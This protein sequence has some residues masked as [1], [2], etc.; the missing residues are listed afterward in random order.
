MKIIKKNE[1]PPEQL[2]NQVDEPGVI[3]PQTK[4]VDIPEQEI[5]SNE[6]EEKD[7]PVLKEKNPQTQ[8]TIPPI[9]ESESE[10]TPNT[11]PKNQTPDVQ[12]F[13]ISESETPPP[14]EKIKNISKII[15]YSSVFI[16]AGLGILLL[17]IYLKNRIDYS[18][19]KSVLEAFINKNIEGKYKDSYELISKESSDKI[20]TG[21]YIKYYKS[22]DSV[23]YAKDSTRKFI[24]SSLD[25]KEVDNLTGN[26]KRFK[27]ESGSIYDK[28]TIK[29]R[30]Y[31]TMFLEDKKW[32]VIWFNSLL[33]SAH[34]E[35]DKS[36]IST[37][38][39]IAKD[40]LIIDPYNGFAYRIICW[41]HFRN[42]NGELSNRINEM[43]NNINQALKLEPDI[44]DNYY[45]LACC[46]VLDNK[47][48]EAIN[49][50]LKGANFNLEKEKKATYYSTL[51]IIYRDI[52][53]DFEN[54]SKYVNIAYNLDSNDTHIVT[55]KGFTFH[56]KEK[57]L[58]ALYYY[59]K[60]LKMKELINTQQASLYYYYSN[61][62]YNIGEYEACKTY[63]KKAYE[64]SPNDPA[65]KGFY[66]LAMK[67]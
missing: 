24:S 49:C 20:T 4:K 35:A 66:Y 42:I 27:T 37:A 7:D 32:K 34:K 2:N 15:L 17:T 59:E 47:I 61:C 43:L 48:D 40:I 60:A 28:D 52:K 3:H 26:Y 38:T 21:E 45:N 56:K 54:Y 62:K 44:G 9:E 5:K 13:D 16:I 23:E 18:N 57:Y 11:K 67:K 65:I 19:P 39:G 1:I 22:A 36:N 29:L 31:T 33:D 25:I 30:F 58:E 55:Q 10:G 8:K 50:I 53:Q 41:A 64:L 6:K 12:S 46:Y 14:T 51:G 63:I